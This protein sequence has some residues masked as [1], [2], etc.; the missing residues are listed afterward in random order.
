MENICVQN[1]TLHVVVD[2]PGESATNNNNEQ[3]LVFTSPKWR[4][5]YV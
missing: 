3:L 5:R 4:A 2:E 1:Q